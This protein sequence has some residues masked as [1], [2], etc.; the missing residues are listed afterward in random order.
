[1]AGDSRKRYWRANLRLVSAL[2]AIWALVAYGLSIAG[3]EVLNRFQ[4]AGFP[5]G[6]WMAQQGSIY[7]FVLLTFVYAVA[8]DRLE[9]RYGIER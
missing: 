7:V 1:M 4:V 6:F 9:K 2:L 5:V 3:V 8:V